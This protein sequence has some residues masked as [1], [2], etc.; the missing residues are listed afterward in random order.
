[1]AWSSGPAPR[2]GTAEHRAWRRA[3]LRRDGY[4]CRLCGYQGSPTA[5]P[6]DIQADHV[7]NVADGGA[8]YDVDNGQTLC[9]P[10]HKAKTGREAA[11]GRA[12]RRRRPPEK[13]P[14]D[15]HS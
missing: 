3:V 10:H 2:T 15:P 8:E 5:K 13:H 6:A 12:R 14:G 11:A 7:E 1:M 9:L 4:R